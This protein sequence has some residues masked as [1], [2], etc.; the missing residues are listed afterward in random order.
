MNHIVIVGAG[1]SGMAAAIMA[2]D[3]KIKVT[4]IDRQERIGK[5]ILLT[6]NGRCNLS[7]NDIDSSHYVTDDSDRLTE[8]LNAYRTNEIPFWNSLGLMTKEKNGCIYPLS[9]QAATVLNVLRLRLSELNIHV[10]TD[11]EVSSV[12]K[13]DGLFYIENETGDEKITADILILACGGKAGVYK[14]Q[15]RN[16][17]KL[18][19]KLGHQVLPCYPALVQTICEGDYFKSISG[20]RADVRISL[21][22]NSSFISEE[23]GELQ[24]TDKG[25]SGIAVFQLTRYLGSALKEGQKGI[26]HIDFLPGIS[27]DT[28]YQL[29]TERRKNMSRRTAEELFTGILH[30]KIIIMMLKQLNI[31]PTSKIQDIGDDRF[32]ELL[33]LFKDFRVNIKSLNDF[34]HAQ[35]STGGVPLSEVSSHLASVLVPDLYIIGEMLN[36][37]GACGG[38]N[39]HF[40]AATGYLAGKHAKETLLQNNE[41]KDSE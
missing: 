3:K 17:Y 29:M 28:W 25:L 30:K 32:N 2:A 10:R 33:D 34:T 11:F 23:A 13:K 9:G 7:N 35:I 22:L 40:A 5:K 15:S 37:A 6:G 4:L 38:Y 20:V 27:K 1:M 24:I 39:L 19:H 8:I 18:C 41:S 12:C 36:A 31:S 14:E 26:F 16:G 21:Y